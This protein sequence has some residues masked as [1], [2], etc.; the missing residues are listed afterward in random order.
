M[1]ARKALIVTYYWPPAG[2]PGVQRVVKFVRQLADLGWQLVILTV[3][4]PT[5]PVSDPSLLSHIP[6]DCKVYK[7]KSLEPFGAYRS[8][9]GKAAGEAISKDIIVRRSD[10][11]WNEKIARLIRANLFIPDARLGWLPFLLLT[12]RRIIRR[13]RPTVIFSTSPP[14]SLQLGAALLARL[15]GCHWVADFRDPW[16]EAYWESEIEKSR[17]SFVLN[18]FLEHRVLSSADQVTTVSEGIGALFHRKSRCFYTV[19]YNGFETIN[20]ESVTAARF[21]LLFIGNLSKYQSPEPIFRALAQLPAGVLAQTEIVFLG[22]VFDDFTPLF[23]HYRQLPIVRQAYLPFDAM[24]TYARAASLLLLI[25]H[26]TSYTRDYVTA[27][28]FDYL[29][30]RKPILALGLKGSIGEH[31]LTETASGCLF[32]YGDTAGIANYIRQQYES[33]LLTGSLLLP[34][35][36]AL[37]RYTTRHNVIQLDKLLNKEFV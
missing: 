10:E 20:T 31:I 12:G 32:D 4:K 16:V 2:G 33:W 3:E 28:L 8:F 1:A 6:P 11:K 23:S 27:K 36:P 29:A 18:R 7:T 37:E 35:H 5:S 21:R 30:L 14:H 22:K 24:M 34:D 19:L 13:E 9:T 26:Q 15:S 25:F 17:F